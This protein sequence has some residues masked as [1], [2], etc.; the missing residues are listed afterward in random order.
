MT[1]R[2]GSTRM[3][4]SAGAIICGLLINGTA[5]SAPCT[6]LHPPGLT[7]WPDGFATVAAFTSLF[8]LP[9]LDSKTTTGCEGVSIN[10]EGNSL[11]S[12]MYSGAAQAT[13]AT[14]R[15]RAFSNYAPVVQAEA[16][17]VLTFALVPTVP[18]PPKDGA[19]VSFHVEADGIY[20]GSIGVPI[21][22]TGGG[23]Y[24]SL[25]AAARGQNSNTEITSRYTDTNG[26]DLPYTR[27]ENIGRKAIVQATIDYTDYFAPGDNWF[28]LDLIA[29]SYPQSFADFANTSKI[30]S[31]SVNTP[32]YRL[33][34]PDGLF[35][36][37]P[38]QAG[39][40]ILADLGPVAPPTSVPEPGT[41][42][43]L[44]G[45]LA[46]VASRP[47]RRSSPGHPATRCIA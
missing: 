10:G 7:R 47:A 26:V 37:D 1:L 36:A 12:G 6:N 5:A 40:Y 39:R 22:S 4:A 28:L 2:L 16:R 46:A 31:I 38:N 29:R 18:L 42:L 33:D 27:G 20:G 19:Q 43:L 23:G 45:G 9:I 21:G 30:T 17:S 13:P 11:Y 34:L 3:L 25:T 44:L 8:Q 15:A 14:V 35:V 24:F 41:W 32:G